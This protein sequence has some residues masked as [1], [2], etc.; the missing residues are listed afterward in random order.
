MGRPRSRPTRR[1]RVD[2]DEYARSW[3][4]TGHPAALEWI[5]LRDSQGRNIGSAEEVWRAYG[6]AMLAADPDSCTH[7]LKM[8]GRPRRR[9]RR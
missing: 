2:L 9:A 5:G 4:A 1:V 6:E 7:A 8:F 3:M